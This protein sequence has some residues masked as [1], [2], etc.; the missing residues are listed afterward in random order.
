MV[1]C[2]VRERHLVVLACLGPHVHG[3]PEGMLTSSSVNVPATSPMYRVQRDLLALVF[4]SCVTPCCP[5]A[6]PDMAERHRVDSRPRRTSSCPV[7]NSEDEVA[8]S[9]ISVELTFVTAQQ[10]RCPPRARHACQVRVRGCVACSLPAC[11]GSAT[12]RRSMT[13]CFGAL[14]VVVHVPAEPVPVHVVGRR[15]RR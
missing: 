12:R 2:E 7:L 14:R 3:T 9:R 5:S 6:S 15:I 11:A 10:Q 1:G 13:E 4:K 8:V